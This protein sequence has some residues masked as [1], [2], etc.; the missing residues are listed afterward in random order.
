MANAEVIQVNKDN[1]MSCQQRL[2]ASAAGTVALGQM[3]HQD[4]PLKHLM[5]A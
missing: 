4:W 2:P 1:F 3:P 5:F